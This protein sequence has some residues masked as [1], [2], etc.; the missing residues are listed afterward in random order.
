MAMQ[1]YFYREIRGNT[2][3]LIRRLAMRLLKPEQAPKAGDAKAQE[4]LDI[5]LHELENELLVK[6]N[7]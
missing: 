5:W 4:K 6:I 1:R 3:Q 7:D 2:S